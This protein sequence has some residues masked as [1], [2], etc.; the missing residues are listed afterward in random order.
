MC[1]NPKGS[2]PL[3]FVSSEIGT[4]LC[5]LVFHPWAA[6]FIILQVLEDLSLSLIPA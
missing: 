2:G 6:C 4:N 3:R 5:F 1:N